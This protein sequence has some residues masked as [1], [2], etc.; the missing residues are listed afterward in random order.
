MRQASAFFL[1]PIV[2]LVP[3]TLRQRVYLEITRGS[4]YGLAFGD[5]L[6]CAN[7]QSGE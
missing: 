1:C 4:P 3:R 2:V 7:L 5:V 6:G